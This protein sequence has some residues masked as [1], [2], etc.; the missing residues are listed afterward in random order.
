MFYTYFNNI[1]DIHAPLKEHRV[2]DIKQPEWLSQEIL[3]S[4]EMRDYYNPAGTVRTMYVHCTY[5]WYN[6]RTM[7]VHCTYSARWEETWG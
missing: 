6:V 4:I 1:V 3:Q 2:K 5:S 7:Y